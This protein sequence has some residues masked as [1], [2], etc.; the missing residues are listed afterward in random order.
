MAFVKP[1]KFPLFSSQSIQGKTIDNRFF[2]QKNTLVI[3]AH[4]GCPAAMQLIDDLNEVDTSKFQIL[5]FLENTP[6]QINA[7]NADEKSIWLN[8]RN[9]FKMK[10]IQFDVIA[11]CEKEN[12][13]E[14]D[15]NISIHPQCRKISKKLKVH[16]SP[17]IYHVNQ[18]GEIIQTLDGYSGNKEKDKRLEYTFRKLLF[19]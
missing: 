7:F 1:K 4:L 13:I 18:Q 19:E 16:H 3:L 12:I 11:E 2:E 10:P 6:S 9:N 5:I 15:G 14:K 17:Y 8:L